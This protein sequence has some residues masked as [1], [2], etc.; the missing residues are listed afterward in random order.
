MDEEYDRANE[1]REACLQELY[2]L[3]KDYCDEIS[4]ARGKWK[5]I[6]IKPDS[7]DKFMVELPVSVRVPPEF[8]VKGK[9]GSG[10]KQVN[11][12][13]TADIEEVVERLNNAYDAE[14]EGRARGLATIFAKFDSYR[15]LWSIAVQCSCMLDALG[16]LAE[17]SSQPGWCRPTI[18]ESGGAGTSSISIEKGRHPCV[19]NVYSGDDFVPNDITLGGQGSARVLLLS[20]PNMGGKSTLLRQTSLIAILAQIGCYVPAEAASLTPVDRVFTRLGASD[21]ILQGQSTFFVELSEAAAA[22]RGATHNSLVIMD[23]LGRGTSTFD[24]TALAHAVIKS[25]V[26]DSKCLS[27]FATHYH[28]LLSA[29][30]SDPDAKLGHMASHVEG[31]DI[32]F[33]YRLTDGACPRSFGIN[34][35]RLAGLPEE[36]LAIA[37]ERSEG[38][39]KEAEDERKD[40]E[41]KAKK[42]EALLQAEDVE[43]LRALW[44]EMQD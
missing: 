11:K 12:Y 34:V 38:F 9:R 19:D 41:A 33:L 40:I 6:N 28:S 44:R 23:E 42:I 3:E 18:L 35:A 8:K 4:G 16:S 37:K 5:Y 14:R 43:G 27:L 20:G 22:L 39:E 15:P 32:V 10:A 21:R 31:G 13:Y 24:G 26:S 30:S 2:R 7:K 25:L 17:V 1:E 36:V 29:W